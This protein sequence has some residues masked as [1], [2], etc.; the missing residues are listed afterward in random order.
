MGER[1]FS[2]Y[3]ANQTSDAH[4]VLKLPASQWELLDALDRLRLN[5]GQEPYWQVEDMG[6]FGYLAPHIEEWN[7]YTFNALAQKLSA[8]GGMARIAFA[9]LVELEIRHLRDTNGGVLTMQRILDLT[10][11]TDCCHVLPSIGDDA[12]LGRFYVENDFLPELTSLPDSVL[13]LLDYEKIGRQMRENEDGTF[14]SD[15]YVLRHEELHHAPTD[16]N[17]PPQ[18]PDYM[19]RL[20][21]DSG[22]VELPATPEQL[23]AIDWQSAKLVGYDSAVPELWRFADLNRDGIEQLNE[24]AVQLKTLDEQGQL[25]KFKAVESALQCP[26]LESA[27][28]LTEQLDEYIWDEAISSPSELAREALHSMVSCVDA[29]IMARYMQLHRYGQTELA[30]TNGAIFGYGYVC[31]GDGQPLHAPQQNSAMEMTL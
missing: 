9:G 12:A 18:K 4:T 19:I 22:T 6:D 23:D 21:F 26:D 14:V 20:C 30:R 15:S 10:A 31:R 7:L 1:V 28:A 2:L 5:E 17:Q 25:T 27:M 29:E 16:L 24:L 3:L 8:L 11:S 13:A